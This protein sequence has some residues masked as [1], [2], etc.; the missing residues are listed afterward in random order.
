MF[1]AALFGVSRAYAQGIEATE[2]GST[3]D[4]SLW[5]LFMEA[6]LTVK[7]RYD[8]P[9]AGFDLELGHHC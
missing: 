5:A 7:L 4:V 6:S 2:L 3:V 8:R 9:V 1:E